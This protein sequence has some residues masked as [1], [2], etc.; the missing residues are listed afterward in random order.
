MSMVFSET[1]PLVP[2]KFPF[3]T[4]I[5]HPN[6]GYD[7]SLSL[8][9]LWLYLDPRRGMSIRSM[10]SYMGLLMKAPILNLLSCSEVALLFEQDRNLF[11]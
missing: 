9:D 2:P 7:G 4:K 3:N 11:R 8:Y 10:L 5:F 1:F 6:V